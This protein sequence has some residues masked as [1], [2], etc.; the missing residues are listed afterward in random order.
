[1]HHRL[2]CGSGKVSSTLRHSMS[3]LDPVKGKKYSLVVRPGFSDMMYW[4][5]L[6][7]LLTYSLSEV[8]IL[9]RLH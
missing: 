5:V 1:M 8:R 4:S 6:C 9:I 7:Q 3:G 2:R